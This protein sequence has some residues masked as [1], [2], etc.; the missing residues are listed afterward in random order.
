MTPPATDTE[1]APFTAALETAGVRV[2]RVL[3]ADADRAL[4]DLGSGV[5]AWADPA[6]PIRYTPAVGD[7][8]LCASDGERFWIIGVIRGA[9][10]VSL[11][12]FGDV[13][14]RS[15]GGTLR[16]GGS[17]A[18]EVQTGRLSILADT[19]STVARSVKESLGALV[20]TITGRRLV[21]AGSDYRIV[22]GIA[23]QRSERMHSVASKEARIDGSTV[24]LG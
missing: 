8:L 20:Q 3:E 19:I 5:R 9:G 10:S 21:R 18:V 23:F 16:L 1:S 7:S 15:L 4:L 11:A 14:V 17:E 13:E 24:H 22:D 12:A 2:G 6:M